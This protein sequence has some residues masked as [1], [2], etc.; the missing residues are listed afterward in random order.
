MD[1]DSNQ[2]DELKGQ[3]EQLQRE[4]QELRIL[5]DSMPVMFW[6]KDSENNRKPVT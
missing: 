5:F 2:N 3:N 6:Q 4:V 1:N